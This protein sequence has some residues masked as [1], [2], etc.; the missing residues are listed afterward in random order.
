MT[1]FP[2]QI[3]DALLAADLNAAIAGGGA[4]PA[5]G[6]IQAAIDALPATG[7][8]VRLSPNTTY[9]VTT[10]I[11]SSKPNVRLSASD[12][13]AVIQRGP[14]LAGTLLQLMG[15][16]C[17]IE[18][19]TFDGNGSVNTSGQAE[20]QISGANSRITNV[21]VINSAG[22]I[23]VAATGAGCRVDHCTL[24]GMGTS[25]STQRGYGIWAINHVQVFIDHNKITG[26]GIDGIGVDGPG[27]IV[28]ANYIKGCHCWSGSA[29]AQTAIY[30]YVGAD[31]G[32][33]FSNNF[34]GQGG[35]VTSGALEAGGN[36]LTIS[37]NTIVNQ[38]GGAIGVDSGHGITI[39]GN[40]IVNVGLDG[41][42]AQDGITIQPGVTDFS[43]TG[44]R[45]GDDATP[46]TMRWP[47]IV[48]TGA[49]DRYAITGNVLAPNTDANNR[50][51]DGGTGVI[52][53]IQDNA[54]AD[55]VVPYAV[56]GTTTQLYSGSHVQRLQNSGT[57]AIT[58]IAAQNTMR[59]TVK[60]LLPNAA[61]VFTAGN[62]INNT[63]TATPN[64][65]L[66]MVCDDLGKWWVR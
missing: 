57:L 44:N 17:L 10:A 5:G 8:E 51:V 9:V 13:S 36:N 60:I 52:K 27:S 40:T 16:G 62:N 19:M 35:S 39:T 58:S 1:G 48:Q 6:S 34:I 32:T 25:L 55:T 37:G 3:G 56:S 24:T 15:A 49:S 20:V 61:F 50:I 12:W 2:W 38:Y 28:D 65:P 42:G 31:A 11:A 66:I 7:G 41:S 4:V 29:G 30:P 45:V 59:G 23:M 54:G 64:V 21:Q 26:T 33:V 43:I 18:G 14:A 22:V 47:I 53:V 63:V 46:P